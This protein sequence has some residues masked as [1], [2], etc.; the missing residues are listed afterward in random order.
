MADRSAHRTLA[1]EVDAPTSTDRATLPWPWWLVVGA[2]AVGVV[3]AGWLLLA[4]LAALGWLTAA[5]AALPDALRL[6]SAVLLLAYG[7]EVVIAGQPVSIAPLLLTGVLVLLGQPVAA[8]AARQAAAADARPDD[9]GALWVDGGPVVA[10]VAAGYAVVH[11]VAVLVLGSTVSPDA[12]WRGA[13]GALVVGGVAGLWGASHALGHD[14][15]RD[16]PVWLRSV[17]SAM[18]AALLLVLA[19]GA[20]ALIVG[21]VGGRERVATL[22]DSLEPGAMGVALL[23]VIQ[24]LYLPN[25]VLWAVSWVLGAGVGL[26]D[27][28]LLTIQVT[29]V[30]FL[31]AIPVLG[32]VPEAGI[33]PPAMLWWLATG[34]LAGV[35][36]ATLVALAR[37]RARFDETALVGGLTGVAVGLLIVLLASLSGGGLG[38][39][40][41]AA[42]GPETAALVITA[43]S[44]L[45]L[46]GL[47]AGLII[48][49][50]RLVVHRAPMGE[51]TA[52]QPEK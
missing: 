6:A 45:G 35:V 8:L 23:V 16:W 17:P 19:S 41:L 25:L 24:L 52:E 50:V 5:D 48:G 42:V 27:G 12:A 15:R 47:L 4:G 18:G 32:I 13:I 46:A 37:P 1:L 39:Q 14:P 36:A 26:G 33:H 43:P 44:L 21:L 9:T 51:K 7:A 34:V 2:G 28:S 22:Q 3:A 29:D 31:P 30:G 10:R 38:G 49:L 11:A 40:R 20:A